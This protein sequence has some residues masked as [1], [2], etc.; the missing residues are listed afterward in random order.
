MRLEHARR[1]ELLVDDARELLFLTPQEL[2]GAH[3]QVEHPLLHRLVERDLEA[4]RTRRAHLP[5][6]LPVLRGVEREL[7]R[8][9]GLLDRAG[10]VRD[11]TLARPTDVLVRE[12]PP[13]HVLGDVTVQ[14]VDLVG[15]PRVAALTR[16]AHAESP[17][18]AP[19]RVDP[20]AEVVAERAQGA[21]A[22]RTRLAPVPGG[23]SEAPPAQDVRDR[24]VF[25]IDR[26]VGVGETDHLPDV[27]HG[28][29]RVGGHLGAP[30]LVRGSALAQLLAVAPPGLLGE[31]GFTD[32]DE[33][34]W[35]RGEQ[36]DVG[37]VVQELRVIARESL[38]LVEGDVTVFDR[39]QR[40][41]MAARA[42]GPQ[43]TLDWIV[44]YA[45]S[46]GHVHEL[47]V[48]RESL[49]YCYSSA[50]LIYLH[51]FSNQPRSTP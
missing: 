9:P 48:L 38:E 33:R 40:P 2:E 47:P 49:A 12:Q 34:E 45:P 7:A 29:E 26:H 51:W 19:Q 50:I 8:R 11:P 37:G 39:R 30:A 41:A 3:L 36:A 31:S 21:V 1:S 13:E 14:L 44:G 17:V 43:P 27:L 42:D 46:T 4:D 24:P 32:A 16:D 18:R 28:A 15:R 23:P 25:P 20:P 35:A 10:R 6:R 5:E 22:V